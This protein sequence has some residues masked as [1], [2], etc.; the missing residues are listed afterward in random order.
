[1]NSAQNAEEAANVVTEF[2]SSKF[3]LVNAVRGTADGQMCYLN[4]LEFLLG[5]GVMRSGGARLAT[6]LN[7][8]ERKLWLLYLY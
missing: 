8:P 1:M 7:E 5:V 2:I 6:S 3:H 4:P